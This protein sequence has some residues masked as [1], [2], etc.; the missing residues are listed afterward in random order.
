[1][2]FF[3]SF[4]LVQERFCLKNFFFFFSFSNYKKFFLQAGVIIA[5]FFCER[6]IFFGKKCLRLSASGRVRQ[7]TELW[8]TDNKVVNTGKQMLNIPESSLLSETIEYSIKTA[9]M[10][11]VKKLWLGE[12]DIENVRILSDERLSRT[13]HIQL[14]Q[15]RQQR[16]YSC[17][18]QSQLS[19]QKRFPESFLL[20]FYS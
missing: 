13:F 11:M 3:N 4:V 6:R 18:V 8:A 19:S 20:I 15:I 7:V 1:M 10:E 2:N 17:L 9:E 5:T 14:L 12:N 16:I